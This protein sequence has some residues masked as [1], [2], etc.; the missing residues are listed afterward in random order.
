M[1]LFLDLQVARRLLPGQR[2]RRQDRAAVLPP[3][4]RAMQRLAD[5]E[6]LRQ[7]ALDGQQL[8][9][10]AQVAAAAD[11]QAGQGESAQMVEDRQMVPVWP[12]RPD[13]PLMAFSKI[14]T[15]SWTQA[16]AAGCCFAFCRPG[17]SSLR[18]MLNILGVSPC[19]PA[20][21]KQP[22]SLST[23][24]PLL[25]SPLQ[26]LKPHQREGLQFMWNSLVLDFEA[27]SRRCCSCSPAPVA[28]AAALARCFA[29]CRCTG[30]CISAAPV[31]ALGAALM[32]VVISHC[33]N[34][35]L[36]C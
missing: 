3:V 7:G 13:R 21:P 9:A 20:M 35:P 14:A 34:A 17:I 32:A 8:A 29:R 12:D 25:F 19:R 24:P 6:Q 22:P 1:L 31:A 28:A 16:D 33:C 11:L 15:A 10:R 26:C 27:V 23:I 4:N 18:S 36:W 5:R 30:G 2:R